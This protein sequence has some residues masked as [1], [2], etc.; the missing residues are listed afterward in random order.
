MGIK[1][2]PPF[3]RTGNPYPKD[4]PLYYFTSIIFLMIEVFPA[5]R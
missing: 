3:A 1:T 2:T 4:V 5:S